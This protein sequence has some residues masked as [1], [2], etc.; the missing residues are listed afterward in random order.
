MINSSGAGKC[1]AITIKILV[2]NNS[3]SKELL[4]IDELML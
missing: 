1:I 3:E 4:G 2:F